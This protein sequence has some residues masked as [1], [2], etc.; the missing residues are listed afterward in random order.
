MAGDEDLAPL[1]IHD[2]VDPRFRGGGQ[3][4][5][6]RHLLNVLP[7]NGG[8]AGV[9]DPKFIV[10]APKEDGPLVVGMVGVYPEQLF[11]QWVLLD[12]VVIIQSRLGS[13]ADVEGGVYMGFAPLHDPAQLRPV[14][15]VLKGHLFDGSPGDDHAVKFP[16]L[17]LVEGLVEGQQMF[18]GGVL[19]F[20]GGDH[21]QFQ[22]HLQGGVAQQAAELGFGDDFGG[23]QIQK[24]DLQG[25]DVLGLGPSLLHDEDILILQDSGGGQVIGYLNG[26]AASSWL[27]VVQRLGNIRDQVLGVFQAAAQTD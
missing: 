9:G 11:R 5:Q 12:A 21:H 25:T 19:G 4:F 18:L 22:V 23:H 3:D 26:H 13:P 16:V 17:Q 27:Y 20:V 24:H 15:H 14:V 8:V 2:S 10:K 7:V 6:P 1:L